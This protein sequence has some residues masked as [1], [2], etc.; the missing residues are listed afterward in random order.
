MRRGSRSFTQADFPKE[1]PEPKVDLKP[2][3]KNSKRFYDKVMFVLFSL[4]FTYM[5]F[6]VSAPN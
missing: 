4:Q 5:L 3:K 2:K 6:S 1:I